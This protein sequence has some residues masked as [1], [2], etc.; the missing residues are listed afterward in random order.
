MP[1]AR[2]R[3]TPLLAALL[4][5][6]LVFAGCAD[7]DD[8]S[9]A[10]ATT[11]AAEPAG[12]EGQN[13]VTI[14]MKDYAFDVTG[15][16]KAGTSTVVMK[17]T[18]QEMHMA[19]FGLLREGKT[20]ADVQTALQSED[21]AAFQAV[22]AEEVGAPGGLLHP[23]HTQEV[24]TPLLKAGNYALLCFIPTIGDGAPHF[25]KGMVN[26]LEV[27]EG[28]AD[29]P[30]E[31]DAEYTIDDGKIDGP[32]SLGSGE[33]TLGMTAAGDGPHEFFVVRKKEAATTFEDVDKAF[34]DLFEGDT[35]PPAGYVDSLPAVITA[36]V[37]DMPSGTEIFLKVTLEPGTYLIGCAYEPDPE[38]GQEAV[39][40][41]DEMLEVTVT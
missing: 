21:E 4:V 20:L 17:N 10:Q 24:T 41:K 39:A 35:P 13:T 28:D 11:T 16:L 15:S 7:D 26:S 5:L 31:T 32:K 14:D 36:A 27:A 34:T 25:V 38:E 9:G 22:F 18:G 29:V 8:D 40:H 3:A 12:G 19:S 2:H 1:F 6:T 37:F 30:T 23:G 33:V